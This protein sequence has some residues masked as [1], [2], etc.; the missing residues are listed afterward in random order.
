VQLH[1]FLFDCP[2]D[3]TKGIYDGRDDYT[4]CKRYEKKMKQRTDWR[5]RRMMGRV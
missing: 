5:M 2:I 4:K 1:K 3:K